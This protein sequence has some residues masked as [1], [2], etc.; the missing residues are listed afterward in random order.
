MNSK[1]KVFL[2][3]ILILV[4]SLGFAVDVD[5]LQDYQVSTGGNQTCAIDDNETM[6]NIIKTMVNIL[7]VFIHIPTIYSAR[8]TQLSSTCDWD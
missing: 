6:K 4:S 3:A 8:T 1:L 5:G 2:Y 7:S